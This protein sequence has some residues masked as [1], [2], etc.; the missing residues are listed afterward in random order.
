MSFY[1]EQFTKNSSKMSIEINRSDEKT[2][3]VTINNV[4]DDVSDEV[5]SVAADRIVMS[6]VFYNDTDCESVN[7]AYFTEEM[8][9]AVPLKSSGSPSWNNFV[10]ALNYFS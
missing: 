9:I 2:S 4:A 10:D 6:N 8:E 5:A 1:D 3:T 7:D